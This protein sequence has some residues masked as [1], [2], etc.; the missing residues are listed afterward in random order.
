[1]FASNLFLPHQTSEKYLLP[2]VRHQDMNKKCVVIDLDET[3]VHSSFK[4]R[5]G[6]FIGYQI[7]LGV[8]TS[9]I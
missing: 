5:V 7:D 4:V 9:N 2:T 8:R 6:S 3:L 1:M